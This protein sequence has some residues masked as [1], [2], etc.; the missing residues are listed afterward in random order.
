[1]YHCAYMRRVLSICLLL[2]FALGP[3]SAVLP[4]S[5]D[6]SLPACCRRSGA[7]HCA[8]A[9][10]MRSRMASDT[11]LGFTAPATC[12]N[13]PGV[14]ATLTTPADALMASPLSLPMSLMHAH[15]PAAGR[16]AAI[17]NPIRA[18]VGRGP[19]SYLLS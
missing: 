18:N 2:F 5:D 17:E 10:A 6:A 4:G 9:A 8:M 16:A 15:T 19:P 3:L 12:P 1:M 11:T 7:H 13:Y 14:L